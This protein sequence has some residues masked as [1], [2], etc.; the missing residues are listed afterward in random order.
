MSGST[1]RQHSPNGRYSHGLDRQR[2]HQRG[3]PQ[4][5]RR[6]AQ[7]GAGGATLYENLSAAPSYGSGESVDLSDNPANYRALE[8]FLACRAGNATVHTSARLL[9]RN[10]FSGS[11]TVNVL[12]VSAGQPQVTSLTVNIY[13][14]SLSVHGDAA[15]NKVI[16]YR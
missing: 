10:G 7:E 14:S 8:L 6:P 5:R 1:S 16:G 13:G 9:N 12:G 15:V 2:A 3:K 4:G 11:E